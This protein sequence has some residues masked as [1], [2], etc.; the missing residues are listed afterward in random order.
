MAVIITPVEGYTG[1][2]V[3]GLHFEDGR[4]ETDSASVV[5]YARRHGYTVEDDAPQ[6]KPAGRSRSR[7]KTSKG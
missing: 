5:A 7:G 3:A 4:A 6:D 2:G 1:P